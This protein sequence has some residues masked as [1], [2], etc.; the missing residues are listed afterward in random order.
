MICWASKLLLTASSLGPILFTLW[1]VKFSTNWSLKD[2]WIYL[3]VASI[4]MFL[5]WLIIKL[6]RNHL[7]KMP[8]SVENVKTADNKII[9]FVV[10]YLLPLANK[11]L[12]ELN[13]YM[14]GFVALVFFVFVLKTH[15]YHFNP[16]INLLLGYHFYEVKIDG[17]INHI[18]IT[19]RK[20]ADCSNIG[21]IVQLSDYMVMEV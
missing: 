8:I 14:I 19:K 3:A 17:G 11:V 12:P 13:L 1:F 7:E 10:A 18:L 21:Q 9:T 16:L 2:G 20:I 6:A 5:C 4:L 15:S